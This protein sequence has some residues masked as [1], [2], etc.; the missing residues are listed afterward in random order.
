M[1]TKLLHACL[2]TAIT[3]LSCYH[4]TITWPLYVNVA[5]ELLHTFLNKMKITLLS[6]D[7]HM[8]T[9]CSYI[10]VATKLLHT[11]LKYFYVTITWPKG[12]ITIQVSNWELSYH[13]I[14]TWLSHVLLTCVVCISCLVS[15]ISPVSSLTVIPSGANRLPKLRTISAANAF[16]GATYTIC[17]R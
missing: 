7:Y 14:I 15:W 10:E 3:W 9:S 4:V 8:T 5:T 12:I 6:H 13:M 1:A 11:S 2:K 17:E 16:I